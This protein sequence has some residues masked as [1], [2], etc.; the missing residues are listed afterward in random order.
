MLQEADKNLRHEQEHRENLEKELTSKE[1]TVESIR[2]ETEN[3]RLQLQNMTNKEK[4]SDSSVKD[5]EEKCTGLQT[6]KNLLAKVKLELEMRLAELRT[7]IEKE[8]Y[9][10][11][12]ENDQLKVQVAKKAN[13]S[14]D[15]LEHAFAEI[16]EL[17]NV[18]QTLSEER[19]LLRSQITRF[20]D[21][22]VAGEKEIESLK[23]HLSQVM[24]EHR[25]K[26]EENE[27]LKGKY[28]AL[29]AAVEESSEQHREEV[30]RDNFF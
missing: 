3:L 18:I 10:L 21:N 24:N 8:R 14:M 5:L 15:D 28:D 25:Q 26:A 13:I 20:Q 23:E 30:C 29:V 17:K 22:S 11:K 19:E 7:S 16:E 4:L 9:A 2:K 1:D 6:E 12:Y 27:L